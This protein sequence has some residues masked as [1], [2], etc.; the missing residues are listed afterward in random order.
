MVDAAWIARER[1]ARGR[2][3]P[4][5][6]R[7]TAFAIADV[8]AAIAAQGASWFFWVPVTFG[9]GSAFYF[10][11]KHEPNGIATLLLAAL[12]VCC[13]TL[14]WRGRGLPLAFVAAG[15]LFGSVG[16]KARTEW[17]DTRT[18]AAPTGATMVA[19]RVIDVMPVSQKLS[20]ITL[21][22]TAIDGIA[23]DA[24]PSRADIRIANGKGGPP[25]RGRGSP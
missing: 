11:L 6:R 23:P 4:A 25:P 16:A 7:A 18:L 15:L 22:I 10:S 19:G 9:A 1:Q 3:L 12:A 2:F 20:R 5:R 8:R 13:A 17:L 21:E 24:W 14:S